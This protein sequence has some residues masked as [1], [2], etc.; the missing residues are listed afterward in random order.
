MSRF[1]NISVTQGFYLSS[2][3]NKIKSCVAYNRIWLKCPPFAVWVYI[4]C[5]YMSF[6]LLTEDTS[7]VIFFVLELKFASCN[8]LEENEILIL[9][10]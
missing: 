3:Q 7:N 2:S 5:H 1:L 10:F 9:L 8:T 6:Y 4:I